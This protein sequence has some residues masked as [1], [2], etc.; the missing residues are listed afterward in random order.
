MLNNKLY[1]SS[2][3]R[4]LSREKERGVLA[5]H[6]L[7]AITYKGI[8]L[9]VVIC[10]DLWNAKLIEDLVV[11]RKI[12]LLLIPSFTVVPTDYSKYA[13][14]QWL[15]LGISRSREFIIPLVI[16]DHGTHGKEYD[17]GKVSC[18][19]DPSLKSAKMKT[20]EDFINTIPKNE[21]YISRIIDL[22]KIENYRKYRNELG[23]IDF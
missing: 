13:K 10:A 20:Q 19:I 4:V 6:N 9:G 11:A 1:F 22:N 5:G 2:K 23:I 14:Q 12:D 18:I 21:D 16:A 15:S 8:K 3:E 17:V 7:G